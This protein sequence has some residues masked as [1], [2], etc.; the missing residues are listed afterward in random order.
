M[1]TTKEVKTK[2]AIKLWNEKNIKYCE[3]EFSC[4]GDSMND[5]TFIYFTETDSFLDSNLD[6]Y[7]D[8]EVYHNVNFYVNSDGHYLG[9]NGIV[10][11]ELDYDKEN[12][13]YCKTAQSEWTETID[14]ELLIQLT[15]EQAE[16]IRK[17]VSN[18]NGGFDEGVNIN[19]S[20]NFIMTDKEEELQ[21]EIELLVEGDTA[22]FEPKIDEE[23][24]EWYRFESDEN[25]IVNDNNQLVIIMHN[26]Y[27]MYTDSEE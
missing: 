12:F 6:N 15:D 24:Q 11:I 5:Y 25:T 4:G 14:S 3:M 13:T 26:D 1:E 17:N 27:F 23:M 10:H 19:Y 9:E 16:F 8:N 2:E 22:H 21:K 20:R 18:L 7:F